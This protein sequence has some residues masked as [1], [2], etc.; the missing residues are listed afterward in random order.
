[1][2]V[3]ATTLVS[4]IVTY[5]S[6]LYRGSKVIQ[7]DTFSHLQQTNGIWLHVPQ[8]APLVTLDDSHSLMVLEAN[9]PSTINTL[10][11]VTAAHHSPRCYICSQSSNIIFHP[12]NMHTFKESFGRQTPIL[13]RIWQQLQDPHYINKSNKATWVEWV[14]HHSVQCVWPMK[15]S[16]KIS[17][18][19][20]TVPLQAL[21]FLCSATILTYNNEFIYASSSP[22]NWRYSYL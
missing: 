6:M 2:P 1:M 20:R 13:S 21:G 10:F 5:S 16:I 7:P 14:L 17:F 12:G 18:W 15:W 11:T 22:N 4:C 8:L 9:Q 19:M 3:N